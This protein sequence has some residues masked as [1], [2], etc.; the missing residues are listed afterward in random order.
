MVLMGNKMEG[1]VGMKTVF[2]GPKMLSSAQA[3]RHREILYGVFKK[4]SVLFSRKY[5]TCSDNVF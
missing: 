2:S 4:S 1:G 5:G 3:I